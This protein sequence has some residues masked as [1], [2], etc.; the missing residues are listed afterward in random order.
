MIVFLLKQVSLNN[1][2]KIIGVYVNAVIFEYLSSYI[3]QASG[4][5]V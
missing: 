5:L 4:S 3:R 1:Q 2:N